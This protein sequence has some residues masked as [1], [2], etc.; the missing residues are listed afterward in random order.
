MIAWSMGARGIAVRIGS[1]RSL[2]KVVP[3]VLVHARH[4]LTCDQIYGK[5][6]KHGDGFEDDAGEMTDGQN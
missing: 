4:D 1:L 6:A 5:D 2:R 3:L